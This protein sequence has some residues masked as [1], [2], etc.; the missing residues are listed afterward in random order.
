MY[1]LNL[2][3]QHEVKGWGAG[4]AA[5]RCM[6]KAARGWGGGGEGGVEAEAYIHHSTGRAVSTCDYIMSRMSASGSGPAGMPQTG[7]GWKDL[8]QQASAG[9]ATAPVASG[10]WP[11]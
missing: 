1:R 10:A 3:G 7:L 11:P 6:Q 8:W 9:T 2:G 4:L 5:N